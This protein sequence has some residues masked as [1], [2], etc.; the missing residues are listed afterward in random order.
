MVGFTCTA[1]GAGT[2]TTFGVYVTVFVPVPFDPRTCS[3]I[4]LTLD[5]PPLACGRDE[6]QLLR[7]GPERRIGS[8][9][10]AAFDARAGT[11]STIV[12]GVLPEPGV[13]LTMPPFAR[14]SVCTWPVRASVRLTCTPVAPVAAPGRR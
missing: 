11:W 8:R 2:L 6:R 3:V 4:P 9:F 12:S 1:G 14:V 13:Q 7:A 10:A 5:T